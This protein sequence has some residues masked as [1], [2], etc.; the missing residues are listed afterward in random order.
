[1]SCSGPGGDGECEVGAA[2]AGVHRRGGAGPGLPDREDQHILRLGL[3]RRPHGLHRQV[4][5]FQMV[6]NINIAL[7]PEN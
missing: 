7:V 4:G 1:M 3:P 2:A 6:L 5:D